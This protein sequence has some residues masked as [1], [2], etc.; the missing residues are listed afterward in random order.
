MAGA[1]FLKAGGARAK[2]LPCQGGTQRA[3]DLS[4]GRLLD[5]ELA[6]LVRSV[7]GVWRAVLRKH[8]I[9]PA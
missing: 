2:H 8:P 3:P 9:A 6:A 4:A 5:R 7:F 1:R